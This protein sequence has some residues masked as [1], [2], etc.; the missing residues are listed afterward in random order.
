MSGA[1]VVVCMLFMGVSAISAWPCSLDSQFISQAHP[2]Q[3]ELWCRWID[4]ANG[5]VALAYMSDLPPQSVWVAVTT[6]LFQAA[7]VPPSNLSQR[8]GIG[9]MDHE[10]EL[11]QVAL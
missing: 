7:F 10:V 3:L 4:S 9:I 6:C 8:C 2:T 11:L 5:Q 1:C